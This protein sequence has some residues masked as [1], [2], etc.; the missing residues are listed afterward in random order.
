[1]SASGSNVFLGF[2]AV[3]S[4]VQVLSKYLPNEQRFKSYFHHSLNQSVSLLFS[5]F[6]PSCFFLLKKLWKKR[7]SRL[8]QSRILRKIFAE[9]HFSHCH[10]KWLITS[11]LA[12]GS[13]PPVFARTWLVYSWNISHHNKNLNAEMFVTSLRNFFQN[14]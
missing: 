9:P 7:L 12:M 1:M 11:D 3:L 14:Y 13:F 6:H 10:T 8:L 4:I 5:S 2:L